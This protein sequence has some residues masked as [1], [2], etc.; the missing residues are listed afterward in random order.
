[1]L[2]K[3]TRNALQNAASVA[4]LILTTDR[5]IA[6]LPQAKSMPA[7]PGDREV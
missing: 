1:M 2:S 6:E 4:A 5:M 7:M 3:V